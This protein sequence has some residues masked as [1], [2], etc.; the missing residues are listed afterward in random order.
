MLTGSFSLY[1]NVRAAHAMNADSDSYLKT[2]LTG[3]SMNMLKDDTGTQED[4]AGTPGSTVH[5]QII[6]AFNKYLYRQLQQSVKKT[7]TQNVVC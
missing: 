2:S 5:N 4:D 1:G 3:P 7:T 6:D